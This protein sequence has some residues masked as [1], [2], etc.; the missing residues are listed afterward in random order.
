MNKNTLPLVIA[1]VVIVLGGGALWYATKSPAQ[2][3][4]PVIT[5]LPVSVA[6]TTASAPALAP[7]GLP[8]APAGL[9]EGSHVTGRTVWKGITAGDWKIAFSIVSSW[10]A[11]TLSTGGSQAIAQITGGDETTTYFVSRNIRIAEPSGLS[12]TTKKLVIAGVNVVAHIY[13]KP[14]A[15]SAF[16]EFFTLPVGA[17]TYYFRLESKVPSTQVA[18][19][20][21]SL[22][23]IK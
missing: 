2:D 18:E 9:P 23:V 1:A 7:D 15:T 21:E 22:V 20:F 6:T 13:T 10:K 17:D 19:D 8:A 3:T 16:Y 12:Y 4:A 14:N 11:Q 5:P